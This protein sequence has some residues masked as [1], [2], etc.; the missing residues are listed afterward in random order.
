[1]TPEE[2]LCNHLEEWEDNQDG[3]TIEGDGYWFDMYILLE[4]ELN[5]LRRKYALLTIEVQP[6]F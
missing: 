3:L 4:K 5:Q 2:A 1:M 6:E